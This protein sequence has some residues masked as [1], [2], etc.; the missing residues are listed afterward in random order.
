MSEEIREYVRLVFRSLKKSFQF[1]A[2]EEAGGLARRAAVAGVGSDCGC[3]VVEAF[4]VPVLQ[5]L[6]VKKE[7]GELVAGGVTE[8]RESFDEVRRW[9]GL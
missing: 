4:L 1:S 9:V 5:R 6:G 7:S 2:T 3:E 8:R